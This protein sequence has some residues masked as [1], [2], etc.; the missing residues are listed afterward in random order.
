MASLV[1]TRM[2]GVMNMMNELYKDI[3]NKAARL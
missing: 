1:D 2:M 3:Q